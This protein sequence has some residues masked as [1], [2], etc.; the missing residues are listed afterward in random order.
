VI[1]SR[2]TRHGALHSPIPL[3][4]YPALSP[5]PKSHRVIS[6]ADPHRLSPVE[7]CRSKVMGGGGVPSVQISRFRRLSFISFLFFILRPLVA[8]WTLATTLESIRS[9]LFPSQWGC[10]PSLARVGRNQEMINSN[11]DSDPLRPH[12]RISTIVEPSPCP[13]FA[14]PP[15]SFLL[16]YIVP[17]L[18]RAGLAGHVPHSAQRPRSTK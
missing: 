3:P 14:S 15:C 13:R 8:Q 6:F 17:N 2:S 12:P 1:L 4:R 7:S 10:T 16:N 11:F 18:H 5:S 9:G